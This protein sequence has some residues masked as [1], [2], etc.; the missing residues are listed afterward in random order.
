MLH[1]SNRG[2]GII[3]LQSAFK[4]LGACKWHICYVGVAK[5]LGIGYDAVFKRSGAVRLA[6]EMRYTS[7]LRAH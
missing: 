4:S 3:F 2:N 7:L 5:L 6:Y 1:F